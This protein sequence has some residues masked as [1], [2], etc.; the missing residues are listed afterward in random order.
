MHKHNMRN[1]QSTTLSTKST[2]SPM[3]KP[4]LQVTALRKV[5]HANLQDNGSFKFP[6]PNKGYGLAEIINL[7]N[8][9]INF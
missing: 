5:N 3:Q 9:K 8:L 6:T 1:V 7:V 4:V 2:W